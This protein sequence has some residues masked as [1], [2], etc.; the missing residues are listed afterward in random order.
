MVSQTIAIILSI[1]PFIELRGGIPL[2]IASGLNPFD[3]FFLCT[4][5]NILIIIP[6]FLFLDFLHSRLLIFRWY[7][8]LS[9]KIIERARKKAMKVQ[10]D[11][12]TFGFIALA[13]FVAIPLP[14]TGA[15]TGTLIAWLLGLK[16]IK[17]V[18]AIASGVII[19][20][21]LVTLIS[22]GLINGF[23]WIL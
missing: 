14:M 3:A 8:Y 6:I 19:A 17:S 2:S 5:T 12:K 22:V 10:S 9:D 18:I 23:N 4:I 21:I 16:R 11:M 13:I 1:L 20:G 15:W 7:S